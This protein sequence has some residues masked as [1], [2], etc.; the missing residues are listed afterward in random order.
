MK[1][2]LISRGIPSKKDPMWG[3]FEL[4]H[5]KALKSNRHNVVVMSID[6]RMRLSWRTIGVTHKKVDGINMYNFFFP[7]PYRFLPRKLHNFI[8]DF[9]IEKLFK[10]VLEQ[11][12]NFDVIHAHYL[13]NI[14]I[15]SKIKQ[16]YGIPVVGTE[17]WS[18]LKRKPM[19]S[20]VFKDASETYSN[21][22]QLITVSSPLKKII[23]TN[24][25]VNSS[26]VGCVI[27]DVFGYVP[28]KE[29]NVFR[30]V[31]VGSLFKIKGFDILI[32]AFAKANFGSQ[33][34]LYI[35]GDGG[36]KF[37]LESLVKSLGIDKQVFLVGRKTRKEIMEIFSKSSVYLLSSQ[38]ENFATACMEALSS[39]IPAIMT[40]CG[41]P[42]DF[43]DESN[44]YLVEVGNVEEMAEAMHYM[45]NN[46]KKYNR[47][48]ISN[49]FREKYSAKAIAKATEKIYSKI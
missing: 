30:F 49:F 13:P 21:I 25:G 24:F 6:N 42:E 9:F 33:V 48:Q 32:N 28:L 35:V 14:R 44:S 45:K 20:K 23:K 36:L 2:L 37:Q 10:H 18:E 5:A 15:A 31:A 40:K 29:H 39:G 46:I 22:N 38:S 47:K 17:H 8:V 4:D 43:V 11:E 26:F 12:E 34:E 19:K 7:L 41:G 16:K 3:N 27:D 1:I